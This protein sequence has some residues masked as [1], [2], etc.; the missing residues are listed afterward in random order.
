[1][2]AG[3]AAG[4]A[5]GQGGDHEHA[6]PAALPLRGPRDGTVSVARVVQTGPR[7][8]Q[9]RA[10]AEAR[11]VAVAVAGALGRV[12]ALGPLAVT[13]RREEPFAREASLLPLCGA[14]ATVCA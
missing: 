13:P 1:M 9:L 11:P 6:R 7:E 4:A 8:G 10:V 5:L 12:L 14:F 3:S 2:V